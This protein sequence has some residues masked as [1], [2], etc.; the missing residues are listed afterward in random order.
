LPVFLFLFISVFFLLSFFRCVFNPFI[1]H[2]CISLF[3]CFFV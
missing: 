3:R 2:L 1:L